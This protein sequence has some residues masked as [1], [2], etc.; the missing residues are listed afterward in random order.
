VLG[1]ASIVIWASVIPSFFSLLNLYSL[2][3]L[4]SFTNFFVLWV[5]VILYF[6]L[7]HVLKVK[8]NDAIIISVV[9]GVSYYIALS[10]LGKLLLGG[11][12]GMGYWF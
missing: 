9:T 5:F 8:H 1:F 10:V 6:Y 12:Y 3:N 4:F 11:F 2:A 7:V